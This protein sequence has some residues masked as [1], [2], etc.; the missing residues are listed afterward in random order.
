VQKDSSKVYVYLIVSVAACAG[1]LFGFDIAVINGAI[2][3]LRSQFRLSDL[4]T[5][6]AAGSLLLGCAVGAGFA[7][8]LS[9][10]YGRRRILIGAAALFAISWIAAAAPDSLNE[11][12]AARVLAGIATGIASMLAPM[13]IAENSPPELRGRF[14]TFNQLAIVSGILLAYL[15][16]W[17]FAATGPNGWRWMFAAAAAPATAFCAALLFVPESP[18]WLIKEHREEE[19]IRILVR[20]T[21]QKRAHAEAEEIRRTL[22]EEVGSLRE[23]MRPGLRR[24][25]IIAV[26][27][28]IL[29]QISGVNTVL[30]YGAL[31]FREQTEQSA[32]GAIALNVAVGVVNAISTLVAIAVIDK[33]GRKPL[34]LSCAGMA[35]SL[36]W[37]GFAFHIAPPPTMLI[38]VAILCYVFSFGAGMGPGVWVLMSELFPTRVRGRAKAVATVSLWLACLLLTSTFLSLVGAIGTAGAFWLYAG[39]CVFSFFFVWRVPP[40]TK[41]RTLEEIE[42]FWTRAPIIESHPTASPPY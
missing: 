39:I 9:D 3:F 36:T 38:L 11:F 29:Q 21:G 2:V 12:I 34:L 24:P 20:I 13:Y 7:G 30:Y 35:A 1:L 32:T 41:G 40:E 19:A 15:A 26:T 18:R 16:N 23:L 28:A 10:R 17:A 33:I 6:V 42:Q 25:L 8:I 31:I 14:V 4:Q 22:K 5:E 27:L 37:M